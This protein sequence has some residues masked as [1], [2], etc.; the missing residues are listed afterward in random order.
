M[1]EGTKVAWRRIQVGITS[2]TRAEILAGLKEGDAV[3]L[4]SDRPLK[5]GL[6]VTPI[7]P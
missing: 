7:Y 2:E 6:A 4:P 1:L 3:A 5:N